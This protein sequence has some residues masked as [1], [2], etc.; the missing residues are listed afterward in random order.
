MYEEAIFKEVSRFADDI[1]REQF[2]DFRFV[3]KGNTYYIE[4]KRNILDAYYLDTILQRLA[5]S[6]VD[7]L[8][9]IAED[10]TEEAK[11]KGR[12]YG[13]LLVNFKEIRDLE[14][15]ILEY[16]RNLQSAS[17]LWNLSTRE[18]SVISR[19]LKI[20]KHRDSRKNISEILRLNPSPE[21]I[22]SILNKE[23]ANSYFIFL[24][25]Q[26]FS[27]SDDPEFHLLQEELEKDLTLPFVEV[28]AYSHFIQISLSTRSSLSQVTKIIKREIRKIDGKYA[29]TFWKE[30]QGPMVEDVFDAF[31][32]SISDMEIEHTNGSVIFRFKKPLEIRVSSLRYAVNEFEKPYV[33]SVSF[34][35]Q[36]RVINLTFNP[37]YVIASVPRD[38]FD[39]L[40]LIEIDIKHL[41]EAAFQ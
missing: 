32:H 1:E 26:T 3:F 11:A 7:R 17:V 34:K 4:S 37:L 10:Y 20:P 40:K 36:G 31:R 22:R 18:L 13:I 6:P 2:F 5:I 25:L 21:E 8:I 39:A 23:F 29:F 19:S 27:S 35:T 9:V 15:S 38:R 24:P 33:K 28:D 16:E 30:K 12:L 41:L 14:K